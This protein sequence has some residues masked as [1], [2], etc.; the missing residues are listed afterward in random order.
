MLY[1]IQVLGS[2]HLPLANTAGKVS[3]T[4]SNN[5]T[6]T[7]LSV[8]PDAVV[9][10]VKRE[11]TIKQFEYIRSDAME[12]VATTRLGVGFRD[13]KSVGIVYNVGNGTS[14]L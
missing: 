11:V 13:T 10:V 14:V 1:R 3:T 8:Y 9:A 7:I 5:V 4:G 6:G 12:F 2:S